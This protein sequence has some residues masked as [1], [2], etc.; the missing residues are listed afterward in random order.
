MSEYRYLLF[1]PGAAPTGDE[2]RAFHAAAERAALPVAH[3]KRKPDG[4]L[5]LVFE[6]EAFDRAMR[7]SDA[8][9]AMLLKWR[10]RGAEID[11]HVP[12]ARDVEAWRAL[13]SADE[14]RQAI[15]RPGR[16]YPAERAHRKGIDGREAAA[17]AQLAIE[18]SADAA[19]R[20]RRFAEV[21]PYALWG[22]GAA[23]VLGIGL[24]FGARLS[25]SGLER[26]SDTVERVAADATSA[27]LGAGRRPERP[28]AGDPDE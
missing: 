13:E 19:D 2:L 6:A 10:V 11:A 25:A 20:L 28:R 4:A 16:D 24:Y 23:I 7:L 12:F 21:G 15:V 3:G 9:D 5:A 22:L 27:R 8:L 1:P 18:R 17:R 14:A 26:R